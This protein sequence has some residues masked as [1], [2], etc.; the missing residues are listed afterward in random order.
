MGRPETPADF[1]LVELWEGDQPYGMA[2][3]APE[4]WEKISPGQEE[5]VFYVSEYGR[6][7]MQLEWE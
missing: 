3:L 1:T 5:L 2:Y 4:V 7:R 6:F